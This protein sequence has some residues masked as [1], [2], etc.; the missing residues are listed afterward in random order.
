MRKPRRI[1]A[2]QR[3]R[4]YL[5]LHPGYTTKGKVQN[6]QSVIT[7]TCPLHGKSKMNV[8]ALCNRSMPCLKCLHEAATVTT[9]EFK[10]RAR[11]VHGRKF[12]Y[13]NTVYVNGQ[14]K[15]AI[16]CRKHGE[17]QILPHEHLRGPGG[18]EGCKVGRLT[19]EEFIKRSKALFPRRYDYS[20]TL[21]AGTGQ[22]VTLICKKK[23]H[24]EFTQLASSHLTKKE[25]CPACQQ[26]TRN[27]LGKES[28][29]ARS[30][31][32]SKELKA[33]R[34]T[35]E[36]FLKRAR[37]KHRG[38]YTYENA[39]Y[40]T[41]YDPVMVTCPTHGDFPI[42]PGNLWN[43]SGCP[44]CAKI[45]SSAK[46]RLSPDLY[47]KRARKKHGDRYDLS[48]VQYVTSSVKIKPICPSHGPFM[49]L[50][51]NF[52]KGDGCPDCAD[53]RRVKA[54]IASAHSRD[55]V[56]EFVDVHG[57]EYNYSKVVYKG[58]SAPVTIVCRKHGE[59]R[60][61]P[62]IHLDDKGCPKCGKELQQARRYLKQDEAIA[63]FREEHG[64]LFDYSKF[65]YKDYKTKG[66][67]ICRRHGEFQITP[68]KHVEGQGCASCLESIGERQ[69]ARWLQEN[70]IEF[71]RQYA[72]KLRE[73][74]SM[75]QRV[76]YDFLLP[77]RAILI[78]FDGEQHFRPVAFF[79]MKMELAKQTFE[80]T[81]KRDKAKTKWARDNGY[82]LIRLRYDEVLVEGLQAALKASSD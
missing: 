18:C 10:K 75:Q 61:K 60:Q 59:F 28:I 48:Q 19:Q 67:V 58:L 38:K 77:E 23:G 68:Q 53:E 11:K 71:V 63:L 43:G 41:Q 81:V 14:T 47:L 22:H 17:F 35:Q 13:S 69:I 44:A 34:L 64:D 37:K 80:K 49:V 55:I 26:I 1:P 30:L 74:H 51:S 39:A 36:E 76:R 66:T 15:V 5:A 46:K 4:D 7:L 6:L 70:K 62:R 40:R 29:S 57:S 72:V 45:S 79:G 33:R 50:P 56:K 31:G 9:E 2:A 42:R 21:Y 82:T 16:R 20:K 54:V 32:V 12:D 25:G 78:E 27:P 73:S 24:G 52:L 8:L 3:L 65:V